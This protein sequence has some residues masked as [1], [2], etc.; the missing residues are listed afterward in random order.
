MSWKLVT[1][2]DS[3]RKF[4]LSDDF[5]KYYKNKPVP[6]GYGALSEFTYKRTYAR[7]RSEMNSEL[8]GTEDWWETCRRVIE[9]MFTIQKKHCIAH[10]LPWI[11]SKAQKTAKD[12]YDRL[13]H[14]KWTP[15]GRGLWMMG[16]RYIEEVTG[17]CLFNCAAVSTGNVLADDPADPFAW[18]MDALM[19][20]V[21]VGFDTLGAGKLIV[22]GPANND[23]TFV[24]EDSRQGWVE[25]LRMLMNS[26]FL[27]NPRV[28]M[29][30][31][32]IRK[33][34]EP[35]R[36][37]GGIAA[38][39]EP[40]RKLH[41]DIAKVLQSKI[42]CA[43]SSVDITDI[44][45]MIGRCVVSGNVRRSALLSLGTIGDSAFL[46]M[47]DPHK[48]KNELMSWRWASNNS[49]EVGIGS[50]YSEIG[51]QT[52]VNGEP[53]YVWLSN[54]KEYGRFADGK[55]FLD[56]R[57]V[58]PNP[59]AEQILEHKELCCLGECYPARHE[60]ID[61]LIKTLKVAYLYS[62]TVTLVNTHWKETNAVMLK[63]RRIGLSMTGIVQAINKFGMAEFV[64]MLDKGYKFLKDLDAVYS[65]WLCVPRSK[66]ITTVKP[67]GTV[68]VLAG[69]TPGVHFPHAK[70]YIRRV[71]ISAADPLL[72]EIRNAGY[73]C[74]DDKYSTD[75]VVVEFPVEEPFFVRGKNDVSMWEQLE[76]AALMQ[77]FWADNAVS[78]T[79]TF[80]SHEA[81]DIRHA[82]DLFQYRLKTVS[83]LPIQ[84]HGYELPP[85]EE[86]S[87]ERY[88]E[89]ISRVNKD[90]LLTGNSGLH[91]PDQYCETDYCVVRNETRKQDELKI[92]QGE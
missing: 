23:C 13:F 44:M 27:G 18:T 35:I 75:T 92:N 87:G 3:I 90:K 37:F 42:G 36:G 1:G 60:D 15:P 22:A 78:V 7:R 40:L 64:G 63:N 10:D 33:A 69:A 29:D 49:V 47:K 71:R 17:A 67:S 80:K 20:G 65:D 28:I 19:L 24:I 26:Y 68:S 53:G 14:L 81:K 51:N 16:T 39:A 52:A 48:F 32:K 84:D 31:S 25:S 79:V 86:I 58:C 41:E 91:L 12:A 46:Q 83:F 73:N 59:C 8:E 6:W 11:N 77:Y 38:G 43:L 88:K 85:Y 56:M 30:Y 45:D 89:L 62:K 21:G 72:E 74:V 50:D 5:L 82:L 66:K 70:Y 2:E 61:D 55:N 9:G 4:T 76:L 34:G 57:V 54:C